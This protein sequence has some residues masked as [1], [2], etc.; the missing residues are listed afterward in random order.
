M[1]SGGGSAEVRTQRQRDP[2]LEPFRDS[3]SLKVIPH[4]VSPNRGREL[5]FIA[6]ICQR[7]K[8]R[9]GVKPTRPGYQ[10]WPEAQSS[11]LPG[12]MLR[13]AGFCNFWKLTL[14]CSCSLFSPEGVEGGCG[15][16]V[17]AGLPPGALSAQ[18]L[19]LFVSKL[20]RRA[21]PSSPLM[22]ADDVWA[23]FRPCCHLSHAH[24]AD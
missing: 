6:S 14:C 15:F 4:V 17:W 18:G 24:S 16:G 10:G 12:L 2:A 23:A 3:A 8:L 7:G 11:G 13:H 9:F 19:L 1:A 21:P 22:S 5:A 20:A